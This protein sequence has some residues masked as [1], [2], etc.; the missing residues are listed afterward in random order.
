MILHI[1]TPT[2]QHH[3]ICYYDCHYTITVIY[4]SSAVLIK[5]YHMYLL[6]GVWIIKKKGQ[7]DPFII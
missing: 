1:I 5:T 4:M 6:L 3:T 7:L 2:R